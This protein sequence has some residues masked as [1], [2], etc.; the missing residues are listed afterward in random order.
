MSFARR[1]AV[2]ALTSSNLL[3]ARPASFIPDTP[4]GREQ[5]S[6]NATASLT[7]VVR[8]AMIVGVARKFP[9]GGAEICDVARKFPVAF[10][11]PGAPLSRA[12]LAT[13]NRA[14]SRY[15]TMP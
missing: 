4:R 8:L 6:S 10:C 1:S 12:S 5:N 11:L 14:R 9:P 2:H 3:C 15:L 7:A 13:A